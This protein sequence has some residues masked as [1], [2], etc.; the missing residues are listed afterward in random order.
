MKKDPHAAREAAKYAHPIPSREFIIEHLF[1]RKHPANLR[2][3]LTEL[4]ITDEEGKEALRRRLRAM[5]RDGQLEPLTKR[6]YW[7][8]GKHL[9]VEG[10]LT[11]DKFRKL[12]CIP[13]AG[14]AKILIP[15]Y[16]AN[17][18]VHGNKV[19]VSVP[20]LA[21]TK[22]EILEGKIVEVLAEAPAKQLVGR[23]VRDKSANYVISHDKETPGDIIIPAHQEQGALDGDIVLVELTTSASRWD[24]P[25]GKVI[26]VIGN[27]NNKGVEIE[28][29]IHGFALPHQW[30]EEVEQQTAKFALEITN[31]LLRQRVDLRELPLVTIDGED[32]KDF[33]D[34]VYCRPKAGGGW[35]L[36]VAIADVSHYVKEHTPLD[37]EAALRGNSV[38][39]PGK[40]IPMLPEKL[41]N[42]LC[43][44]VPDVDRLCMV[45]EMAISSDGKLG[46]Y[47]FYQAVMRSRARLTYTKVAKILA[48]ESQQ[49]ALTHADIL[50]DLF[51]LEQLYLA[52][53]KQR[54]IRGAIDFETIS[55]QII[56][57]SKGKI[58]SIQAQERN[59]AHKIIEE[60]ML[61]ANVATAKFLQRHKIPGLYRIHESPPADKVADL[62]TFLNELG[63]SLGR[64]QMPQ[65]L[66]YGDLVRKIKHR[67]DA[68]VI[69]T[70][71]LRSLS[72]AVYSPD[73]IGHFGLAFPA[74]VH[75]T[76]PIRRYPD[77][78]VHRQIKRVLAGEWSAVAND[79]TAAANEIDT[80]T[81]A[82]QQKQVEYFK[83]LGVHC[84]ATERRADDATRYVEQWLKCQ[85]MCKHIGD[86]FVG[87]VSGVNR[88][89]F[90]VELTG[91]Y[92]DGLVHVSNLRNDYYNFDPIQHQ[93]IGERTGIIYALGM[94]ITVIVAKVNVDERKIDLEV[95]A[96]KTG[97]TSKADKNSKSGRAGKNDKN[98]K[99]SKSDKISKNSGKH[100]SKG[101]RIGKSKTKPDKHKH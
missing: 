9:L 62:R 8:Y 15:S 84:S 4:A 24:D 82:Q 61:C 6:R 5:V 16:N 94:E 27:E 31:Q 43:S 54:E 46:K 35:Q 101:K 33:D 19:V 91:I 40:V 74:Y 99:R 89:G 25:L 12:W 70:I 29:A 7:P 50:P 79:G 37:K 51:N 71:L 75:F 76:S 95:V 80:V 98:S 44:L 92:V 77:L 2:Q 69:Q 57:N 52:L 10:I 86:T 78:I 60:C 42:N 88:F 66:D 65:P 20:D 18:A 30:P 100:Q 68:S 58:N 97:K 67:P 85:Y 90:F 13:S 59:I 32:A 17:L 73:N 36:Y 26:K 47:K 53:H 96:S 28:A 81:E 34:A 41:S 39:F 21:A 11:F 56:F 72:Q 1:A 55:T 22:A 64:K 45:C 3:L 63:L 83:Q 49:L 48:K 93:L 38:Y 14:G 87:I 23:F